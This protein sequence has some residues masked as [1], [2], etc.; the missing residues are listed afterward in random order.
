MP[1]SNRGFPSGR[2]LCWA[3]RHARWTDHLPQLCCPFDTSQ[4][5]IGSTVFCAVLA[6]QITEAF[7][8]S[9]Q[10]ELKHRHCVPSSPKRYFTMSTTARQILDKLRDPNAMS[11]LQALHLCAPC[12]G[13]VDG[14]APVSMRLGASRAIFEDMSSGCCRGLLPGG[15]REV[16]GV[17][18]SRG[19][20]YALVRRPLG[21][22]ALVALCG[23][24]SKFWARGPKGDRPKFGGSFAFPPPAPEH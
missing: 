2:H 21:A 3:S 17:H 9:M 22:W 15:L 6:D 20:A 12:L 24:R 18:G 23:P 7:A 16:P 11:R 14:R 5:R 8:F 10:S 1:A 13:M 19:M 4:R